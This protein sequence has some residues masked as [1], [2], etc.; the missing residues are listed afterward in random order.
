MKR[1]IRKIVLWAFGGMKVL[2]A[3]KLKQEFDRV[4][5]IELT[6]SVKGDQLHFTGSRFHNQE[7]WVGFKN[8]KGQTLVGYDDDGKFV[9]SDDQN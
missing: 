7:R 4:M 8:D 9:W 3:L 6:A 1:L 2:E 5:D